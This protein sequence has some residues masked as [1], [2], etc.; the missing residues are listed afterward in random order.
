MADMN[1]ATKKG[2]KKKSRKI[3]VQSTSKS[4]RIFKARGS[5]N[6]RKGRPRNDAVPKKRPAEP[7]S[8]YLPKQKKVKKANPHSLSKSVSDNKA[9]ERRH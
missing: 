7:S 5:M 1:T 6:S 2:R 9:A 4:R 3:K 8:S